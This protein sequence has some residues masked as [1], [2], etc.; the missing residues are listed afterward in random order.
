MFRPLQ[1]PLFP[2]NTSWFDADPK[3]YLTRPDFLEFQ[4]LAGIDLRDLLSGETVSKQ[5]Y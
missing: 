1:T 2:I 3:A 5:K 4:E